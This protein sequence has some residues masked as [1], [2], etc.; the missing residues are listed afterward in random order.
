MRCELSI[1]KMFI[2]PR[3]H[4]SVRPNSNLLNTSFSFICFHL[5]LAFHDLFR[6]ILFEWHLCQPTQIIQKSP[7]YRLNLPV[8]HASHQISHIQRKG[9][10][11]TCTCIL[12]DFWPFWLLKKWLGLLHVTF[13]VRSLKVHGAQKTKYQACYEVRP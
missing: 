6:C 7:R 3:K 12:A 10:T 1:E 13:E 4:I 11:C 2:T 5:Q 9:L 8:S